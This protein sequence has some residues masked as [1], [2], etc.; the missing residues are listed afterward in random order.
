ME[1][2]ARTESSPAFAELPT[3]DDELKSAMKGENELRWRA[4]KANG[5]AGM[6]GQRMPD[7]EAVKL[8]IYL[9]EEPDTL[10]CVD[11]GR[12]LLISRHCRRSRN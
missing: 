6:K 8:N 3:P 1:H 12:A 7:G 9:G 10:D 4:R 2:V 11:S 5:E